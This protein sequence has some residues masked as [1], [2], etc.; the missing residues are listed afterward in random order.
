MSISFVS[1]CFA[2]IGLAASVAACAS[3]GG[4]GGV[5]SYTSPGDYGGKDTLLP[6]VAQDMAQPDI[7]PDMAQPD[8]MPDTAQPDVGVDVPAA[9]IPGDT[10]PSL[11]DK[12]CQLAADNCKGANAL[13]ADDAACQT[14][15]ATIPATG[16]DGDTSGNTLQCRIYHL[17]EAQ[18]N[19]VLH[20]PHGKVESAACI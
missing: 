14:A 20:C 4:G 10:A 8:V 16:T 19:P 18:A 3:S 7:M 13:Y 9:D 1:R 6:D 5:D 11:C 15:C 2:V 12:Y 17:T